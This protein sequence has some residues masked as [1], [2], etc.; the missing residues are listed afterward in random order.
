MAERDLS[1]ADILPLWDLPEGA[2]ARLI[3]ISENVTYRVEAPGWR[4][5]LRVHRP[6]YHG[7]TEI[8]SE[9]AWMTSLAEAGIPVPEVIPGR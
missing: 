8:R 2:R 1:P 6:G 5:I 9:L 3:N 4:S 7:E